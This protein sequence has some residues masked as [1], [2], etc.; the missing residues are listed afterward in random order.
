VWE[1]EEECYFVC[2]DDGVPLFF[3]FDGDDC[4]GGVISGV[5]GGG[6][7]DGRRMMEVGDGINELA[8][9]LPSTGWGRFVDD[10]LWGIYGD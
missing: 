9:G 7:C 2:E 10:I 8:G 5:H 1:V 3:V 6:G 4:G